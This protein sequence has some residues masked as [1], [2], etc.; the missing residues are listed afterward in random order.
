MEESKQSKSKVLIVE[1]SRTTVNVITRR[2]NQEEGFPYE[3]ADSYAQAREMLAEDPLRFFIAVVDLQLLD[4]PNGEVVDYVISKG[5]PLIVLSAIYQEK[6]RGMMM[7]KA[8][9][10]YVVKRSFQEL[11]YLISIVRR[12]KDNLNRK[13]MVVDDSRSCRLVLARYLARQSLTV[14]EAESAEEAL[15]ILEKQPEICLIITDQNMDGMT[16]ADMI[17]QIRGK[18]PRTELAIIGVSASN[19]KSLNALFLK[20]GANDF[21]AK[22][23]SY[24]ELFCR[25]TQNIDAVVLQKQLRESAALDT[26]TN[27]YSR[28]YLMRTGDIFHKN[29]QRNNVK[30]VICCMK[31]IGFEALND[32]HGPHVGE[33]AL[34]HASERLNS[35]LRQSDI[36]ARVGGAEFCLLCIG[37]EVETAHIVISRLVQSVENNAF[38]CDDESFYIKVDAYVSHP[39][40]DTF[41]DC[42]KDARQ[43]MLDVKD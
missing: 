31:I 21:F 8:I 13:V 14:I 9:V 36:V 37:V 22:P 4:A 30:Y 7:D 33:E 6:V 39:R 32:E 18:H 19:N 40:C 15:S 5:I 35:V 43:R 12:V 10:D 38:E 34:R 17:V 27:C 11:D 20:S 29:Y 41:G 1:D 24:E 23:F 42:L 16:G 2:L 25:V 3:V 26:L 28:K